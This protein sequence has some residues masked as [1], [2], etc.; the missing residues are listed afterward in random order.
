MMNKKSIEVVIERFC[1][2]MDGLK[3]RG[4]EGCMLW[5]GWSEGDDQ[6]VFCGR[7]VG[8]DGILEGYLDLWKRREKIFGAVLLFFR[9][10]KEIPNSGLDR[11]EFLFGRMGW[12]GSQMGE[13]FD[14]DTGIRKCACGPMRIVLRGIVWA[15]KPHPILTREPNRKRV[16]I[17]ITFF[18]QW[19]QKAF[20]ELECD[21]LKRRKILVPK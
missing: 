3:R 5:F 1:G 14:G 21:G 2:R 20:E 10:K 17:L 18:G 7:F 13:R 6:S 12:V 8:G 11:K 4:S 9:G 19:M 16:A 15:R